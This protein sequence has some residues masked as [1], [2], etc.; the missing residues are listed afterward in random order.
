M[1]NLCVVA[2][3]TVLSGCLNLEECVHIERLRVYYSIYSVYNDNYSHGFVFIMIMM[4]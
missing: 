4:M 3:V 1:I 2:A